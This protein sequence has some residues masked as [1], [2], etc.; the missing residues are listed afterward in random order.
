MI[1]KQAL[2]GV[3]LF[4]FSTVSFPQ[5][6]KIKGKLVDEENQAVN[7]DNVILLNADSVFIAGTVS[8]PNG[9]FSFQKQKKAS[10][11]LSVSLMEYTPIMLRLHNLQENLDLG[12]LHLSPGIVALEEV[13]VKGTNRVSRIDRQVLYPTNEQIKKSVN[14]LDLTQQLGIGGLLILYHSHTESVFLQKAKRKRE[15]CH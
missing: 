11:M 3:I 9:N 5:N 1:M 4:L 13:T 8:D 6:I 15:F 14:G 7:Y 12:T 2:I 10:Y